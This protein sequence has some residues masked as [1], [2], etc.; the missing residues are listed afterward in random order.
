[1]RLFFFIVL[2]G[3]F[4]STSVDALNMTWT[5]LDHPDAMDTMAMGIDGNRIVG[6]Y[7]D[8]TGAYSHGFL[9]QNGTW[10]DLDYPGAIETLPTGISGNRIVG[11]YQ[12]TL[13]ESMSFL[14]EGG[15]WSTFQKPGAAKT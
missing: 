8:S 12:V 14:Y 11:T 15:S 9:Y 2:V 10:Q 13:G 5:T 1:M 4:Y 6:Q 7:M 3:I